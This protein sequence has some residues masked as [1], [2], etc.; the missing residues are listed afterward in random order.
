MVEL[1]NESADAAT[2]NYGTANYLSVSAEEETRR[3]L[4]RTTYLTALADAHSTWNRGPY[5]DLSGR[6]T[7]NKEVVVGPPGPRPVES[8]YELSNN[9]LGEVSGLAKDQVL[10]H[11]E[12]IL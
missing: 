2:N 3:Q 4:W 1:D 7:D 11:V 10:A 8:I 5:T 12:N 9:R 6:V